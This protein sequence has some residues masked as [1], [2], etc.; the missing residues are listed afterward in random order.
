MNLTSHA[1]GCFKIKLLE[2]G[3]GQ[4]SKKAVKGRIKFVLPSS[5]IKYKDLPSGTNLI[6]QCMDDL[7]A[8]SILV[9]DP[10][11][12][13]S[14]YQWCSYILQALTTGAQSFP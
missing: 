3:E 1:R 8:H 12:L 11:S 9:F 4:S 14:L 10:L 7:E 5:T 13:D 6:L 2:G